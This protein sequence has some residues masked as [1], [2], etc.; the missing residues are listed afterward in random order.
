M[1]E[2]DDDVI[3]MEEIIR[4]T[5]ADHSLAAASMMPLSICGS[6]KQNKMKE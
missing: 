1:D 5:I 3:G 6:R 2:T 4:N